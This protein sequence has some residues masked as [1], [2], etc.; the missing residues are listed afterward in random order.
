MLKENKIQFFNN[1]RELYLKVRKNVFEIFRSSRQRENI[2]I[3]F[4]FKRSYRY[5]THSTS[6]T[7]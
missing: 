3:F 1:S 5:I 4:K 2:I 6:T 7:S